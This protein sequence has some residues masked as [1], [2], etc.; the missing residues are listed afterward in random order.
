[1]LYERAASE[2]KSL[3]L[4][5]GMHHSLLQGETDENRDRVFADMR[6]WID[7]RV[8]RYSAAVPAAND[9]TKEVTMA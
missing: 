7:E 3:I 6:A 8:R 5:E 9:D 2:D 1:M 4:Y